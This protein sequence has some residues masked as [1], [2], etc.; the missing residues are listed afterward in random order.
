MARFTWTKASERKLRVWFTLEGLSFEQMAKRLGLSRSA[1]AGKIQ[2]MG[3]IGHG[4]NR[5]GARR[6]PPPP[7]ASPP[8]PGARCHW[9]I[10]DPKLPGF[11]FCSKPVPAGTIYCPEHAAKAYVRSDSTRIRSARPAAQA[12]WQA[13]P[14]SKISAAR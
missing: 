5:P 6:S 3:L 11:H 1:V 2:R 9:P 10:G 8:I 14:K 12:L 4:L 7:G 13:K